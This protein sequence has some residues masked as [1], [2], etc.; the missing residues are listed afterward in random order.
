MGVLGS[1]PGAVGSVLSY[2]FD[3]GRKRLF[4]SACNL[5]HKLVE[6]PLAEYTIAF[7]FELEGR[8]PRDD[9]LTHWTRR[10]VGGAAH[11]GTGLAHVD[12]SG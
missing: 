6:L 7:T 12:S 8:R 11:G 9:R 1:V 2:L 10:A 3:F 5:P 4:R